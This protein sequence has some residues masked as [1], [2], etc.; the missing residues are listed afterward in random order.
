MREKKM[1]EE[2]EGGCVLSEGNRSRLRS[3][4]A[5]GREMCVCVC[6]CVCVEVRRKAGYNGIREGR[7]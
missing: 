5:R 2:K 4:L 3:N 1:E 6:V 7:R